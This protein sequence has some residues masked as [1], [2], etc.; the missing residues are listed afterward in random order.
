[1]RNRMRWST[2]FVFG[3]SVGLMFGCGSRPPEAEPSASTPAKVPATDGEANDGHDEHAHAEHG[4]H[5]GMLVELG[6]E[7]YHAEVVHDEQA[8]TVTVYLLDGSAKES[9]ATEATE[10]VINLK[11]A[12]QGEQF[13]LAAAPQEGDK[14]GTSSRFQSDD[15]EL[16]A[17][18]DA[19]G[20][21][22]R[23][24][25]DIAGKSYSGKIAHA[26]DH[27]HEHGHPHGTGKPH[28]H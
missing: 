8:G 19:E 4:P 22:A 25:I 17:D 28:N 23:L 12:G 14:P 5:Q 3:V 1:M 21:E 11:H 26:H 18:L 13:K 9:V 27:V 10:I 7:R 15:K 24:A 2:L 6:N 20:A 16:S